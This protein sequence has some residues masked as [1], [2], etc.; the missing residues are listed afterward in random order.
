MLSLKARTRITD[1]RP[2]YELFRLVR[3]FSVR[4]YDP[5]SPST[6]PERTLALRINRKEWMRLIA[7]YNLFWVP[8]GKKKPRN[9][10]LRGA[11]WHAGMCF[12]EGRRRPVWLLDSALERLP[13]GTTLP[14]AWGKVEKLVEYDTRPEPKWKDWAW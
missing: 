1:A 9:Y 5:E 4:G 7:D 12:L 14:A 13:E 11:F 2:P 6:F 8:P 3:P 10:E